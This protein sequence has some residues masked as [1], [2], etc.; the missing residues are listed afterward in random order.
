MPFY[1][2]I[3]A[4]YLWRGGPCRNTAG[5]ACQGDA[6]LPDR[7]PAFG[8]GGAEAA[9]A[10]PA[11]LPFHAR[12]ETNLPADAARP[13]H[14]RL[15]R[16]AGCLTP[17]RCDRQGDGDGLSQCRKDEILPRCIRRL[18]PC[19]TGNGCRYRS[20][21]PPRR[22]SE[23]DP[24]RISERWGQW[25]R[26]GRHRGGYP[27]R[28][29]RTK[30]SE[31]QSR[32]AHSPGAGLS[33]PAGGG[34]V[35][36]SLRAHRACGA[37][38]AACSVGGT[39]C[40]TIDHLRTLRRGYTQSGTT[41]RCD[42]LR[43][44]ERHACRHRSC[45]GGRTRCDLS[46]AGNRVD[47]ADGIDL[48]RAVRR[49][50]RCDPLGTVRRRTAGCMAQD[51]G[52]RGG[53]RDRYPVGGIRSGCPTR[54]DPHRRGTRIH[55]Q[56]GDE[57]EIFRTRHCPIPVRVSQRRDAPCFRDTVPALLLQGAKRD[58]HAHLPDQT[59]WKRQTAIRDHL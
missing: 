6:V 19:R 24:C 51:P 9:P 4:L 30:P 31:C 56:V 28:A 20:H 58:L 35:S 23:T 17:R 12:T 38:R 46:R 47:T 15:H 50:D 13:F 25:L 37:C 26:Y 49:P 32:T 53:C 34:R 14:L 18:P 11:D 1:K 36:Q 44:N 33:R 43:E 59:I 16:P 27:H 52:R 29:E 57:S 2:G 40:R 41:A 54:Y 10:Y 45:A 3:H 5:R 48:P 39:V 8:I 22:K 21:L 42:R 7:R 55:V